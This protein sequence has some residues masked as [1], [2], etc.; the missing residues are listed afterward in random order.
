MNTDDNISEQNRIYSCTAHQS[1]R[2]ARIPYPF[3][4]EASPV[5]SLFFGMLQRKEGMNLIRFAERALCKSKTREI[6][7]IKRNTT[8]RLDGLCERAREKS[9]IFFL[10]ARLQRSARHVMSPPLME[11]NKGRCCLWHFKR[12]KIPELNNVKIIFNA[13]E[14]LRNDGLFRCTAKMGNV[15]FLILIISALISFGVVLL[16]TTKYRIVTNGPPISSLSSVILFYCSKDVVIS[17]GR[18]LIQ[19]FTLRFK[20]TYCTSS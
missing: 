6:L 19:S 9:L 3:S 2:V 12:R 7:R 11:R 1:A 10:F 16:V 8:R 13:I 17:F 5:S 14:C 18:S 4:I 15:P 20:E